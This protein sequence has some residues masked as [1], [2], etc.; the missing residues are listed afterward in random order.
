MLFVK[1]GIWKNYDELEESMSLPEI[2][3]TIEEVYE[4][5]WQDKK[6]TASIQGID[7]PDKDTKSSKEVME[8]LVNKAN[9]ILSGAD[10]DNPASVEAQK[11]RSMGIDYETM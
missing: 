3:E 8:N 10:P 6:F 2:F 11:F 4:V 7:I 1:L 5:D 9:A